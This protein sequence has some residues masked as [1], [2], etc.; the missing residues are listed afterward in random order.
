M[1]E[2]WKK[3]TI[4]SPPRIHAP[5][6]R[7]T[8]GGHRTRIKKLSE[9]LFDVLF[10]VLCFVLWERYCKITPNS[11]E[12]LKGIPNI[13]LVFPADQYLISKEQLSNFS[14]QPESLVPP[15]LFEDRVH[16]VG[17]RARP[18]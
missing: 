7:A 12:Y 15:R 9:S 6:L 3:K 17:E 5:P 2:K 16:H 4:P 8:R 1:R 10:D 11:I 18:L 14:E 13:Y